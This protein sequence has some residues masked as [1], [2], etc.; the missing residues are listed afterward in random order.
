MY[1]CKKISDQRK[2]PMRQMK[3]RI[4]KCKSCSTKN[5]SPKDIHTFEILYEDWY[6]TSCKKY[7]IPDIPDHIPDLQWNRYLIKYVK[8]IMNYD[9]K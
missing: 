5:K 9:Y 2:I 6:C 8:N 3:T 4:L 7:V 1:Y